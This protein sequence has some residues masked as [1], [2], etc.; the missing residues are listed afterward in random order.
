MGVSISLPCEGGIVEALAV[1]NE[2]GGGRKDP[3]RSSMTVGSVRWGARAIGAVS[4]SARSQALRIGRSM[5]CVCSLR[6]S[7]RHSRYLFSVDRLDRCLAPGRPICGMSN[8]NRA[9]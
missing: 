7:L 5:S 2:R 8:A 3:A 1:G 6:A 9:V 4:V